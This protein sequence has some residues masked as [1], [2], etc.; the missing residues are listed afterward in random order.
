MAFQ[1][2]GMNPALVLDH[3]RDMK[4]VYD[5][6]Q[7]LPVPQLYEYLLKQEKEYIHSNANN[8]A[9]AVHML[10]PKKFIFDA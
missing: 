8:Y 6:V 9:K 5:D 3:L 10:H 4:K 1:N 7:D 2:S